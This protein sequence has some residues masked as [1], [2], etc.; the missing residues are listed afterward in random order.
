MQ[1]L[2]NT[3][4][5]LLYHLTMTT[6]F[7]SHSAE[8]KNTARELSH[9]LGK[10]G[11]KV[12]LDEEQ[13]LPGDSIAGE[14]SKAIDASDAVLFLI[15]GA[16]SKNRWLSSEV[17]TALA[18]GK[19]IVP[20]V[21]DQ[22]A[23]V[24]ILLQD[25][26]YLDLSREP[27]LGVAAQK[28]VQSLSRPLEEEGELAFRTER[29]QVER[30][31]LEREQQQLALLKEKREVEIRSMTFSAMFVFMCLAAASLFYFLER[32]PGEFSFLGSVIG[33][34]IGAATAEVGHYFRSRIQ[35]KNLNRGVKQ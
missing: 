29:I 5:C 19:K 1:K 16:Y 7:I 34:L 24:P 25:R 4:L 13:L 31:Q 27:D 23:E 18:Y 28:I 9:Q 8:D 2:S 10:V 17:A 15:S 22:K 35:I 32:K 20:V 6:I 21:L 14:I 3:L 26:L 30:E 33:T 12:W 11:A